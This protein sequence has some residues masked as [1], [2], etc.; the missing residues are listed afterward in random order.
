[1]AAWNLQFSRVLRSL[2]RIEEINN[3]DSDEFLDALLTFFQNCWHLKE[4]IRNDDGLPTHV[5]SAITREAEKLESLQ[6]CADLANGSKH[7][8]LT[9]PRKGAILWAP[10][11]SASQMPR[12]EKYFHGYRGGMELLPSMGRQNPAM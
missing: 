2:K 7:L 1:M 8:K 3:D 4:W 12:R 9:T 6:F 5:R 10:G 11:L